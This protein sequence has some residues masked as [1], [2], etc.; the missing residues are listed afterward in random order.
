MWIEASKTGV[1]VTVYVRG[2]VP[3]KLTYFDFRGKYLRSALLSYRFLF[4]GWQA[5][6][7]VKSVTLVRLVLLLHFFEYG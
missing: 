3:E 5:T 4:L 6:N 7:Y 2:D 1:V